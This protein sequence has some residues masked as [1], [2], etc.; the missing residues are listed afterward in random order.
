MSLPRKVR[1]GTVNLEWGMGEAALTRAGRK[2]ARKLD[3]AGF[4]ELRAAAGRAAV[5]HG[6]GVKFGWRE[7]GECP[8]A[9]RKRRLRVIKGS[10]R[11]CAA[12]TPG[13]AGVTPRLPI[14]RVAYEHA[15]NPNIRFSVFS[16]HLVPLTLHGRPRTD[17]TAWRTAHWDAHWRELGKMVRADVA[18]GWTTFVV[19][20][21]NNTHLG[22]AQIRT[23]HPTARFLNHAGIDAVIVIPGRSCGVRKARRFRF[24]TGSDHKGAAATVLLTE[25][26]P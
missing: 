6:L 8:Q 10:R 7:G 26:K 15:K 9:F 14:L 21:G 12:V 11:Y 4:Q 2:V 23:L 5:K 13:L 18:A 24:A 1:I 16:T 22:L 3:V 17:H 19:L 20:D 25:G